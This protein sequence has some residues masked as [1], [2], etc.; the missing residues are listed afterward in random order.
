MASFL[1]LVMLWNH[2][3]NSHNNTINSNNIKNIY[4]VVS[5]TKGLSKSF[6]NVCGKVGIQFHF[7]EGNTTKNPLVA[8]KDRDNITQKSRIIYRYMCN[9]L[10]CNEKY[11]GHLQGLLE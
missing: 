1:F 6:K 9:Q 8:P 2:S 3:T 11:I 7:K 10:D 4:M 5:Y